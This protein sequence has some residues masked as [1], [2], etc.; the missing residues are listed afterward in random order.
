MLIEDTIH[1]EVETVSNAMTFEVAPFD[2]WDEAY[3]H[4]RDTRPGSQCR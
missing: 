2:S 1:Y 4:Y 3:S